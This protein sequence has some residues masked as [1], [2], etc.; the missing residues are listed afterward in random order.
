MEHHVETI[1]ADGCGSSVAA[2]RLPC[3]KPS[4]TCV[5]MA[6]GLQTAA[7]TMNEILANM[8][9]WTPYF[10][11]GVVGSGTSFV[12]FYVQ[13]EAM[14]RIGEACFWA[15]ILGVISLILGAAS[16]GTFARWSDRTNRRWALACNGALTLLPTLGSM[17]LLGGRWIHF[18]VALMIGSVMKGL[19][20]VAFS[21]NL[22][23]VAAYEI[24]DPQWPDLICGLFP[25][26]VTLVQVLLVGA[27]AIAIL[28]LQPLD[29]LTYTNIFLFG[30][31]SLFLLFFVLIARVRS[32][33]ARSQPEEGTG[34]RSCH[35][36]LAW[37][38]CRHPG[39]RRLN[40]SLS[41]LGLAEGFCSAAIQLYIQDYFPSQLQ[42]KRTG[43]GKVRWFSA[44]D[45]LLPHNPEGQGLQAEA[46]WMMKSSAAIDVSVHLSLKLLLVPGLLICGDLL[47]RLGP[48]K[49]ARWL[50]LPAL[51]SI[52][53]TTSLVFFRPPWWMGTVVMASSFSSLL[54]VPL[55]RLMALV[56][57]EGR[58]AES[59]AAVGVSES[60]ATLVAAELM[61]LLHF[62]LRQ[63]GHSGL[64]P[65]IPLL[66]ASTLRFAALG[67]ITGP[68][69]RSS[70][71][72]RQLLTEEAEV[73]ALQ[74]SPTAPA[75]SLATADSPRAP[76][77]L[78]RQATSHD[79]E[80][81]EPGSQGAGSSLDG[82]RQGP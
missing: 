59:F 63:T 1:K 49:L 26:V 19:C 67:P 2:Q 75:D 24:A 77:L 11:N 64:P 62:G 25:A 82:P 14:K 7:I 47:Q 9:L 40:L 13:R 28:L 68:T 72:P 10:V 3:K 43:P 60:L 81:P 58:L 27:L 50:A 17:V 6:T 70:L 73:D 34:T 38:L 46:L 33:P 41:L 29:F 30:S 32:K 22:G 5:M 12:S 53:L 79:D 16:A 54:R 48:I 66:A 56:A 35:V 78:G 69:A 45:S 36:G 4:L 44:G 20:L 8:L 39:I 71:I 76:V 37:I 42:H 65:W 51:A 55:V 57:P 18:F 52:C 61:M 15:D 80:K 21:N 23:F 31:L 74:G